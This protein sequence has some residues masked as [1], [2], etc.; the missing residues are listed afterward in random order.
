[1]NT[2]NLSDA[3]AR[4]AALRGRNLALDMTRGKPS[5]EQLDLSEGILTVLEAG[6]CTGEGGDYRNY[7]IGTGI[8]EA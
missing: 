2:T 8:V 4:F 7:G 3:E 6:D 5:P 1:M